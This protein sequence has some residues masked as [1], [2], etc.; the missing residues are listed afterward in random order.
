MDDVINQLMNA[1]ERIKS[2]SHEHS[3]L[4]ERVLE[5]NTAAKLAWRKLLNTF[6]QEEVCDY[7]FQP[8]D[9]RFGDSDFFLPDFNER[10]AVIRNVLFMI[11]S[12]GSVSDGM[13][14][15]V[16]SEI[17]AAIEQFGGKISGILSFFN[18]DVTPPRPFCTIGELTQIRP[19]G[20]G[21]TD[22]SCIFRYVQD[23]MNEVPSCIVIFTDGIGDYPP[24]EMAAGIPVLWILYGNADFQQW[25]NTARVI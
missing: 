6:L 15:A 11:D 5:R 21:G 17:S 23:Y 9:R 7:S 24:E 12:S 2:F 25:G 1:I 20:Y 19:T 10:D 18:T 3:R 22:F 14:S 13:L 8:P 16:Y 4:L